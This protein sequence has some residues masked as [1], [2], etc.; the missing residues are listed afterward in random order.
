MRRTNTASETLPGA[1]NLKTA[2]EFASIS[3]P[4]MLELVNRQDFPAFKVGRRW[5]IP[6]AD[7]VCWLS[8]QAAKRT[9][10]D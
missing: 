4:T 9:C 10:I 3:T 5:V 7:F 2:A 1:F 6:R 8:E